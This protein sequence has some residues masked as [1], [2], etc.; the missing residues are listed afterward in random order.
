[1]V[2]L[3]FLVLGIAG[4]GLM[5]VV[6][7]QSQQQTNVVAFGQVSQTQDTQRVL[8]YTPSAAQSLRTQNR[9]LFFEAGWCANCRDALK[10][11]ETRSA[12]IPASV[13]V[14]RANFD[15]ET[16]LRKKYGVHYQHTF[17]VLD[18][19]D[20]V[21]KMWVGGGVDELKKELELLGII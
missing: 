20:Q 11:L 1:M 10:E 6:L 5:A 15:F 8:E 9:V 18:T 3:L 14:L 7:P 21:V 19:S 16:E 17:V 13:T 4:V 2:R 12:E